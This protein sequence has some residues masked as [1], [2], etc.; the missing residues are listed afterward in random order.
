VEEEEEEEEEA[1]LMAESR[2]S[3]SGGIEEDR[4]S[5]MG[6]I[7]RVPEEHRDEVEADSWFW[8]P[9]ASEKKAIVHGG[10]DGG[11]VRERERGFTSVD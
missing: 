1:A 8:A 5:G 9:S 2:G 7:R 6:K 10:D 4:G 3:V 11:G